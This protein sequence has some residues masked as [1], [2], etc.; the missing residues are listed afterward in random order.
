[1]QRQSFEWVK[2]AGSLQWEFFRESLATLRN[3]G[4]DVFV[5]VG[6]FNE[7]LLTDESRLAYR[8]LRGEMLA[9]LESESV[10][11]IA[12]DPLPSN[13]YAD[14][15]HPLKQGYVLLAQELLVD[16]AFKA[17]MAD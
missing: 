14:A 7:H 4:N 13:L 1:M 3:R 15:S 16:E 12:P 2:P 17:F 9:W 11:H 6:P 10:P 8:Q 5:V